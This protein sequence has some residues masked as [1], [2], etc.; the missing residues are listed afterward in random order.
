MIV[1]LVIEVVELQMIAVSVIV[2]NSSN[3]CVG[4]SNSGTKT[5]AVI[6]VSSNL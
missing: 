2:S 1:I 5:V 4:S 3:S 6:I